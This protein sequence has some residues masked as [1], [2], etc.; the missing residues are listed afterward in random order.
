VVLARGNIPCDVLLIGEA[1]GQSED[2]IGRPFCGPA[3]HL[4]DGI[5]KDA[6]VGIDR[7]LKIA[8]TN[9]VACIPL[10]EELEKVHEPPEECVKAC[11]PRLKE[12]VRLCK[13]K[14]IVQVGDCAGKY[15]YEAELFA[16][17]TW[18]PKGKEPM[19][20]HIP[21]PAH[22]IRQDISNRGL[23]IQRTVVTLRDALE[24]L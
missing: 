14:M 13:P 5:I 10:D 20:I 12:F 18:M 19:L 8:F 24:D 2:V 3:G 4:L 22:I 1:P 21:H 11:F 15:V 16:P 23:I 7:I 9:L 6:F 17:F